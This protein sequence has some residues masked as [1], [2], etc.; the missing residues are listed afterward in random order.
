[1]HYGDRIMPNAVNKNRLFVQY[2]L[3]LLLNAEQKIE[4]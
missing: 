1:M 4:F 3:A 2:Y